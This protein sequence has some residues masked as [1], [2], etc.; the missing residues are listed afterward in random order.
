VETVFAIGILLIVV[1][2]ILA[3]TTSSLFGQKESELQI[4]ANNLAR[5]AIEIVR[6]QRDSNWLAGQ[7]WDSGLVDEVGENI[8]A[9]VNF[10]K[11]DN[12]WEISFYPAS[13]IS[14]QSQLYLSPEGIY[15]HNQTAQSEKTVFLRH[16]I[17]S[18][19]CQTKDPNGNDLAEQ[20]KEQCIAGSES[21]IGIKVTSIVDWQENGGLRQV[22][23][24]D[25]LYEWK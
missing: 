24:D 4:V 14:S 5:E 23:L 16:L 18:S 21:K 6:N 11:E 15:S 19:I 9:V 17:I 10:I 22:K 2:A 25:L 13:L 12:R 20:I 8:N 1:S 3:L 7:K